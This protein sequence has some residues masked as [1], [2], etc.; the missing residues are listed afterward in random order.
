MPLTVPIPVGQLMVQ[1]QQKAAVSRQQLLE[2]VA[3]PSIAST[4]MSTDVTI[5][6]RRRSSAALLRNSRAEAKGLAQVVVR[7]RRDD[8]QP[9]PRP[10]EPDRTR[11]KPPNQCA[12]H[13]GHASRLHGRQRRC[14]RSRVSFRSNR[15]ARATGSLSQDPDTGG[16]SLRARARD[17][18]GSAAS[19]SRR[20]RSASA[21]ID[22][23]TLER[24]W[25]AGKGW[26][27]GVT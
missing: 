4:R 17:S 24:F 5:A 22:T 16:L 8:H 2:D 14:G 23:T 3:L 12:R 10:R 6:R 15:C 11:A 7:A 20:S 9:E 21:S 25:V 27:M 19:R 1:A 18:P 26:V 13:T